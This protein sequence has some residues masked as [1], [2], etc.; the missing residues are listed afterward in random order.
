LKG[1]GLVTFDPAMILCTLLKVIM[2]G[3]A[4]FNK[5]N[6]QGNTVGFLLNLEMNYKTRGNY[7]YI[8]YWLTKS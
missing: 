4:Q 3:S 6:V 8:K 1:E 5:L 2:I 7:D